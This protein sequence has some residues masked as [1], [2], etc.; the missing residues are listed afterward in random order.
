MPVT[1]GTSNCPAAYSP[2]LKTVKLTSA[3]K[4]K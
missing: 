3:E 2:M 1:L 4:E